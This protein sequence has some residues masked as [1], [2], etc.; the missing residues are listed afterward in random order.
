M[1]YIDVAASRSVPCPEAMPASPH[2]RTW[3]SVLAVGLLGC[4]AVAW[5]S[6][7]RATPTPLLAGVTGGSGDALA[8]AQ[9]CELGSPEHCNDLGVSYLHG[10]GVS[11]N[12]DLAF[13]A[14][15]RACRD[16]SPDACSNL[17]ALY[18]SGVG[19]A[20]SLT[21]AARLYEQACTARGALGCSNL[22]A[23]YARGRG[24]ARD[25]GEAQRLFTLA[26]EI[27]SAAGCNNA[28]QPS[29]H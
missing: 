20:P 21:E 29:L 9:A 2:R 4:F 10:Y 16:G 25:T 13:H 27:G 5:G 23:L 14:F 22:G 7:S 26:C 6:L 1:E 8:L 28:M 3:L 18:E 11:A 17:G 15:E 24:V 19:V 12:A